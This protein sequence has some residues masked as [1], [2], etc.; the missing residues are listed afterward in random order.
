VCNISEGVNFIYFVV[1]LIHLSLFVVVLTDL[2]SILAKML[3]FTAP[4]KH[5][6]LNK[7]Y[8][9]KISRWLSIVLVIII[10]CCFSLYYFLRLALLKSSTTGKTEDSLS[11]LLQ[12]YYI[13]IIIINNNNNNN[14]NNIIIIK[15]I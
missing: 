12:I 13:I 3:F 6:K 5:K 9:K 2:I 11:L 8:F 1:C 4:K 10:V 15:N 14:N 7:N